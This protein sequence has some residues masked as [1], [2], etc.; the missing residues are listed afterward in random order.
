MYEWSIEKHVSQVRQRSADS[1]GRSFLT[2]E[3]RMSHTRTQSC[4]GSAHDVVEARVLAVPGEIRSPIAST[5][6]PSLGRRRSPE[7]RGES[8]RSLLRRSREQLPTV[9]LT[10]TTYRW[11]PRDS[12]SARSYLLERGPVP[13]EAEARPNPQF[14][15]TTNAP[16]PLR[17]VSFDVRAADEDPVLMAMAWRFNERA[18]KIARASGELPRPQAH[19]RSRTDTR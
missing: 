14:T 2:D 8:S 12:V 5:C 16:P 4:R 10:S 6:L 9:R 13:I 7:R 17:V 11:P 15:T 18:P 19:P 1:T 3:Q